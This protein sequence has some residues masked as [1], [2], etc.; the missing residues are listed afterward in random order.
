MMERNVA[1]ADH[2]PNCQHAFAIIGVKFKLTGAAIILACLTCRMATIEN[3]NK[4]ELK[5]DWD[6]T[7]GVRSQQDPAGTH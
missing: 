4:R 3:S 5:D 7:V 2:C 1:P 6:V